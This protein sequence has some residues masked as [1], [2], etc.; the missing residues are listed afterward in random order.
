MLCARSA[1]QTQPVRLAISE[2]LVAD[3]NLTDA[4]A[5]MQIW[6]KRIEADLNVTVQFDSKIFEPTEEIL[7]RIRNGTVDTVALNVVEYRQV[8]GFLEPSHIIAESGAGGTEQYLLLVNRK[9]GIQHLADLRKR[10]LAILKSPKM[11][12]ADAWLATILDEAHCGL[13]ETFFGSLATETKVSRV[14]LPTFFGQTDGCIT[15]QH[16][17]ATMCELNP[18]VGKDLVAIAS[19]APL[20]VTFYI[21]HRNYRGVSRERF[22]KVYSDLPNSPAGRQLSVLFQFESLVVKDTASLAPALAILDSA[23]RIREHGGGRK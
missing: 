2:S 13:A 14:V 10:R 3:V 21:F 20:V 9:S 1:E 6:L 17:F 4:R 22:A 19:S 7:R 15:S 23:E 18:Q 8:A 11:C 5:A 12:V 16:G